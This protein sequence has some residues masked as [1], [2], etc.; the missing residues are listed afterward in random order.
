MEVINNNYKTEYYENQNTEKYNHKML[1]Q[2]TLQYNW[3]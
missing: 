1:L 2:D 3:N